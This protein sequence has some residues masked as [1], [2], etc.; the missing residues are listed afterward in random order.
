MAERLQ[1]LRGTQSWGV[2]IIGTEVEGD[3][4]KETRRGKPRKEEE[5][6]EE[7]K[8]GEEEEEEEGKKLPKKS[9]DLQRL[10]RSVGPASIKVPRLPPV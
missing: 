2:R 4:E 6:A 7:E 10:R 9:Y 1:I 3:E 5:E 8:E